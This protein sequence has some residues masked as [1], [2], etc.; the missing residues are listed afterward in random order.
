M[1]RLK[2]QHLHHGDHD[3]E[4]H[5]GFGTLTKVALKEW[6]AGA[7]S[8]KVD[9]SSGIIV[10]YA[11]M[12]TRWTEGAGWQAHASGFQSMHKVRTYAGA[13]EVTKGLATFID[14]SC[15]NL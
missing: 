3:N 12:M 11:C 6:E 10:D 9:R 14:T 8:L 7:M 5:H 4:C 15:T 2:R 1:H 13:L